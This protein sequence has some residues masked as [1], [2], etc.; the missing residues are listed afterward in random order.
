MLGSYPDENK[1]NILGLAE[2]SISY[3]LIMRIINSK[4]L[5]LR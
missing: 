3:F 1:S 5:L 2:K 4:Q